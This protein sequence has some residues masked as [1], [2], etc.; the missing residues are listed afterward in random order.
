MRRSRS[1]SLVASE[2]FKLVLEDLELLAGCMM[3]DVMSIY[4][5]RLGWAAF[6]R[7]VSGRVGVLV[8]RILKLFVL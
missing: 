8:L 7:V 3:N 5:G 4:G 2:L 6:D 1:W